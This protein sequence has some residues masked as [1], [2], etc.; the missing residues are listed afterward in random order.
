[1]IDP[2]RMFILDGY[3]YLEAW[4]YSANALRTFRL[5]R[6]AAVEVTDVPI[7]DRQVQLKDLPLAG[8][9]RSGMHQLV[10]SS[11]K[12]RPPG[13]PNITRPSRQRGTKMAV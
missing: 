2:L 12:P 4:C 8:S 9:T 10:P 3:G 6:I 1:M 11:C 7:A 5:D 13:S